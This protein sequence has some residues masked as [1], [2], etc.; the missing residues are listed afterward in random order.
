MWT[1]AVGRPHSVHILDRQALTGLITHQCSFVRMTYGL[2]L[3]IQE[4]NQKLGTQE[5]GPPDLKG[6]TFGLYI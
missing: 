2:T 5:E 4:L 1:G 6:V 3:T